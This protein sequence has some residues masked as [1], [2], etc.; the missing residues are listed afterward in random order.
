MKL[1]PGGSGGIAR[2]ISSRPLMSTSTST[3]YERTIDRLYG[4]VADGAP[5]SHG[6]YLNFGLWEPGIRDYVSAAENMV[7]RLWQL[8]EPGPGARILDAG[9]GRGAQDFALLRLAGDVEI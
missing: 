5:D 6:G 3:S 1:G 2:M 4:H 7:A 8:L 9:C